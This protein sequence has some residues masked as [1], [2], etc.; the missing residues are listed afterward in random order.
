[1]LKMSCRSLIYLL[2]AWLLILTC[3]LRIKV[4]AIESVHP[5]FKLA[6]GSSRSL[7]SN[8]SPTWLAENKIHKSPSGPNPVGNHNPPTKQ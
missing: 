6:Q 2:L 5:K 1:M 3:R 8:V 7:N 4:Q